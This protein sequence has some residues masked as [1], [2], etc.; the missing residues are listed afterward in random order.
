MGTA[1]TADEDT[2]TDLSLADIFGSV[3]HSYSRAEAIADGVL[4]DITD[5]SK[6]CGIKFPVALSAAAHALCVSLG[7]EDSAARRALNDVTGRAVDV[8]T[9]LLH[10]IR[11]GAGGDRVAFRVLCVTTSMEPGLVAL[12]ALCGPGDEMEPVITVF[13]ADEPDD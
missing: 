8:C 12:K 6:T 3:I 2:L 11:R 13:L 1:E 9:M 10:G 5:V 4:V 7:A